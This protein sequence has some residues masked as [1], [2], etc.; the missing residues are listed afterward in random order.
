MT[1][2]LDSQIPSSTSP[3]RAHRTAL[4]VLSLIFFAGAVFIVKAALPYFSV[5]EAQFEGYWPRRWWLLAH[6]VTGIVALLSGPVQL[7]LGI[8]DQRPAVH[9]RL[10]FVYMSAVGLSALA[11]YYLAFNTNF[12]VAFGSGL[13]GLAT[14]WLITT[15]MAFV[16]IRRQLY[17]QHKEWMIRSYVVTAAFVAFRVVFPLLQQSGVGTVQEQLA[18]AAWGAWALPLLITEAVIQG[19]KILA[20]RSV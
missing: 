15:G 17:E 7:W 8:S 11:G 1:V 19:R 4:V 3:V 18:M 5:T 9:R 2:T 13:A 6:I 14:A 10:G 12:G 16:A 20:V